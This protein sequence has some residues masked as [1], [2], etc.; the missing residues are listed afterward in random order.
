VTGLI[1]NPF[2]FFFTKLVSRGAECWGLCSCIEESAGRGFMI[3][4]IVIP[5][6]HFS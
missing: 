5:P 1:S 4:E 6:L 3:G 2:I